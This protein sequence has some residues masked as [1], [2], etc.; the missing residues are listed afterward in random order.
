M[1]F[2]RLIRWREKFARV[3]SRRF[4]CDLSYSRHRDIVDVLN[5]FKF[6]HD[7]GVIFFAEKTHLKSSKQRV[8]ERTFRVIFLD[9]TYTAQT[10]HV[11][12]YVMCCAPRQAMWSAANGLQVRGLLVVRWP[13]PNLGHGRSLWTTSRTRQS[14]GVGGPSSLPT[15]S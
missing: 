3:N 10:I 12:N 7:I 11:Y 1:R 13:S 9:S 8:C 5:M 4:Y 15:G 2:F 14:T 6:H